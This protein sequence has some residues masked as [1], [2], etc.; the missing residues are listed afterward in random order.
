M[1]RAQ[2]GQ[3]FGGRQKGAR[4]KVTIARALRAEQEIAEAKASGRK[5]ATQVLD[6]FMHLFA[7]MAAAYQPLPPG[8]EIPA[9][10]A[11]DEAQFEKY[12][13]LAVDCA[14]IL[15][16]FQSPTFKAIVIA[17]PPDTDPNKMRRRFTLTIFD[18]A[19]AALI[20]QRKRDEAA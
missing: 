20:E 16:P 11:P 5:M 13:K 3:R 12:A 9:G 4:N 10:R 17:P 2:K 15:A 6:E 1:P 19:P 8:T 18:G 7:G 14:R